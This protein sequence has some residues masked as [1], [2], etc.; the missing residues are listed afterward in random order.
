MRAALRLLGNQHTA[1]E[2][3]PSHGRVKHSEDRESSMTEGSS[4]DS[5]PSSGLLKG[6]GSRR[7]TST[8]QLPNSRQADA[9]MSLSALIEDRT[10]SARRAAKLQTKLFHSTLGRRT[11]RRRKTF[12][13]DN[14]HIL[15][16]RYRQC[17]ALGCTVVIGR[18][19]RLV[20]EKCEVHLGT[21]AGDR[22]LSGL[23][24]RGISQ[25]GEL[26]LPL[27]GRLGLG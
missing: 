19:C 25:V 14:I 7:R 23:E 18:E 26:D 10:G 15:R 13:L 2:Y 4:W 11:H 22:A 8:Y 1:G 17:S 9:A 16:H 5:F 12:F 3:N 21:K 6:D 27:L 24:L 20:W